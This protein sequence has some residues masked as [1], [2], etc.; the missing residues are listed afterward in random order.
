MHLTRRTARIVT[1]FEPQVERVVVEP[2]AHDEDLLGVVVTLPAEWRRI[3]AGLEASQSCVL[4][5]RW[6][7]AERELLDHPIE[8]P[9]RRPPPFALRG[10]RIPVP[11]SGFCHSL[12]PSFQT[13]GTVAVP[14]R[15]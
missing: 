15:N 4:A 8:P 9:D 11:R 6:I 2:S 10:Q 3:G 12:G 5:R 7:H 13:A 1:R 14:G